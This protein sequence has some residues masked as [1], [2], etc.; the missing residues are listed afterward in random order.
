MTCSH[1]FFRSGNIWLN[2]LSFAVCRLGEIRLQDFKD[3]FDRHGKFRYH[4]KAMDPE[5]G[6]VKEEVWST[7][8]VT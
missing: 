7:V 2:A 3:M 1:F 5:F 6:T 8:I 4:F